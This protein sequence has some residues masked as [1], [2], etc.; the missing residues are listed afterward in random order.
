MLVLVLLASLVGGAVGGEGELMPHG[1]PDFTRLD[2][3]RKCSMSALTERVAELNAACC[4]G[5]AECEVQPPPVCSVECGEVLI[6]LM[7]SCGPLLDALGPMDIADGSRD[8]VAT[9]LHTLE[10]TCDAIP[11]ADIIDT[12]GALQQ[13]GRCPG[14]LMEGVAATAVTDDG[15]RDA[16]AN[17]AALVTLM[18]C[19]SDFCPTCALAGQCDKQCGFCASAEDGG[20]GGGHRLQ[21]VSDHA[22]QPSFF[23]AEATAVTAA[24][25]DSSVDQC[26]GVPAECDARCA[27]TYLPFF[28]RC[29][30]LMRVLLAADMPAY[31]RL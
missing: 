30:D 28:E 14:D 29:A 16:R 13:A 21:G 11:P 25:C 22:C 10:D 4:S 31:S 8:G 2:A 5:D 20:G 26:D 7:D 3:D 19:A 1:L 27:V 23:D 9:I 18:S 12:L 24:C 6:P 15:C 17:C